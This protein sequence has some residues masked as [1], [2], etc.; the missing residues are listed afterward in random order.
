MVVMAKIVEQDKEVQELIEYIAEYEN[1][2]GIDLE[3]WTLEP[4]GGKNKEEKNT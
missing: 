4:K 3:D 1:A 2:Y